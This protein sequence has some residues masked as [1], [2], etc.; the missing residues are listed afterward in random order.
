MSQ[1][2]LAC[3]EWVKKGAH[4]EWELQWPNVQVCYVFNREQWELGVSSHPPKKGQKPHALSFWSSARK[5][6]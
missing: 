2:I 5:W 6:M 3:W 4:R 1:E